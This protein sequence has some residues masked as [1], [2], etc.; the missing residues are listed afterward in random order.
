MTLDFPDTNDF[1]ILRKLYEG[2]VIEIFTNPSDTTTLY[3]EENCD[4]AFKVKLTQSEIFQLAEELKLV[5]QTMEP[6]NYDFEEEV[7]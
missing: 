1:T 3:F 5:A 7:F 6:P 2:R 4:N